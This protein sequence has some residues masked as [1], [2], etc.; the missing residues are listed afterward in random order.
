MGPVLVKFCDNKA[1]DIKFCD[2]LRGSFLCIV[3][4]SISFTIVGRMGI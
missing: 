2:N 4:T 1:C 3:K